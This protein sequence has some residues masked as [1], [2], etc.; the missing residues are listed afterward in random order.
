LGFD[1]DRVGKWRGGTGLFVRIHL[2]R[3]R[4]SWC[5]VTEREG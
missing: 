3:R 2:C 1:K 5:E 4:K